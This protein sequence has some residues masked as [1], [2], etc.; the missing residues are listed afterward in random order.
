[1]SESGGPA[2]RPPRLPSN[3]THATYS[4]HDSR[5]S[6][7]SGGARTRIQ[8]TDYLM[9]EVNG[10]LREHGPHWADRTVGRE[11]VEVALRKLPQGGPTDL[12][13][14]ASDLAGVIAR[15]QAPR[16][17]GGAIGLELETGFELGGLEHADNEYPTLITTPAYSLVVDRTKAMSGPNAEPP[18]GKG[19]G[20]D[21]WHTLVRSA[22]EGSG[23]HRYEVSDAG[24]IRLSDGR[25]LSPDSWV[26]WGD[27][28]VHVPTRM[29]LRGEDGRI[30]PTAVETLRDLPADDTLVPHILWADGSYVYLMP[31]SGGPAVGLPLVVAESDSHTQDVDQGTPEGTDDELVASLVQSGYRVWSGDSAA[32]SVGRLEESL[33]VAGPGSLSYVVTPYAGGTR[34]VAANL[35]G[36]ITWLEYPSGRPAAQPVDTRRLSLDLSADGRLLNP[37]GALRRP[38]LAFFQ[39]IHALLAGFAGRG[40]D[41][42]PSAGPSPAAAVVQAPVSPV[43]GVPGVPDGLAVGDAHLY[44]DAEGRYGVG[45]SGPVGRGWR[46][47]GALAGYSAVFW[48]TH[49]R[50]DEGV[51][52]GEILEESNLSGAVDFLMNSVGMPAS[53]RVAQALHDPPR[54]LA[55]ITH[56]VPGSLPEDTWVWF[57]GERG[58]G[59]SVVLGDGRYRSYL[60]GQDV[61]VEV[62][63]ELWETFGRP[64]TFV[65]AR[66]NVRTGPITTSSELSGPAA[67]HVYQML[68]GRPGDTTP[69]TYSAEDSFDA[70]YHATVEEFP[71]VAN[72]GGWTVWGQGSEY[73]EDRVFVAENQALG[74]LRGQYDSESPK[75]GRVGDP[76]GT[77]YAEG[78]AWNWYLPGYG[79]VVA[80]SRPGQVHTS[81][82]ERLGAPLNPPPEYEVSDSPV[83]DPSL[84][85]A[86]PGLLDHGLPHAMMWRTDRRPLYKFS[87]KTREEVFRDG[88]RPKGNTLGHLLEH[89]YKNPSDTG[90][91]S[92]SRN[93]HYLRDSALNDPGSAQALFRRYQ[94][95]YDVILPGGIDV[96][97][98]LD[99]AS[100]FPDQLEIAFPGG[101]DVRFIRGVQPLVNGSAV[102]EYV[103]NPSFVPDLYLGGDPSQEADATPSET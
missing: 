66:P 96:D 17:R 26:R 49:G 68:S 6:S 33:V 75:A 94:W 34:L 25:E 45:G 58:T 64:Q 53:R 102:G 93:I 36:R 1:L 43:A 37:T 11:E 51:T 9:T 60:P 44:V 85:A 19:K 7:A 88:L 76:A 67:Q 101:I 87:E 100:P 80:S 47:V 52:V 86:L 35:D 16:V 3:T 69:A 5:S 15:G 56:E 12:R 54:R 46:H 63:A 41:A 57:S 55:R 50:R 81:D 92:T 97:A 24:W 77:L 62:P 98:T 71:V 95:R 84:T 48:L 39:P 99:I 83:V 38:D 23:T 22:T 28:F 89:V 32:E 4:T 79:R 82:V 74:G 65:I 2:V 59:A 18:A 31:E 8:V 70:E 103:R 13:G 29:S 61:R 78:P 21:A 90:Y 20:K 72:H 14:L 73:P 10:R 91:V 30:G 42:M 27:D 40:V